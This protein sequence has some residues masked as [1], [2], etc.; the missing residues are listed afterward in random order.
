MNNM[1][2]WSAPAAE[3]KSSK[4][5]LFKFFIPSAVIS[6][7]SFFVDRA[8]F[9]AWALVVVIVYLAAVTFFVL[10]EPMRALVRC[11]QQRSRMRS[12]SR[13]ISDALSQAVEDLLR[14]SSSEHSDTLR[15]LLR[16]AEGWTELKPGI[17]C[18]GEHIETLRTWTLSLKERLAGGSTGSYVS[19]ASEISNLIARYNRFFS[20]RFREFEPIA[21]SPGMSE[22]RLKYLKREWNSRRE[23]HVAFVRDWEALTKKINKEART[24]VCSDYFEQL[25]TLE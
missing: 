9:P 14:L 2:L 7:V 12:L 19:L 21:A 6:L 25:P 17:K 4:D 16:E 15:S 20:N 24:I 5:W 8:K 1:G 13:Q 22:Q 23:R 18:D 11:C 3:D 10:F